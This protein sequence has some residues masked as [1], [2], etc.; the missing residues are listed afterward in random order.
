MHDFLTTFSHIISEKKLI[1]EEWFEEAWLSC[2]PSIYCSVDL[3][4]SGKKIC[5]VDTNLFPAGFNNLSEQAQK[6]A[7]NEFQKLFSSRFDGIKNI[8]IIAEQHTRNK[9]YVD[10]LHILKSCI[11]NAGF[12]VEI[13][14]PI[15]TSSEILLECSTKKILPA[16][17]LHKKA[18]KV[19]TGNDFVPDVIVLNNDL[20]S[21]VISILENIEQPIMPAL[22]LG[23]YARRKSH[24][25]SVYDKVVREFC[26]LI[27]LDPWFI[28]TFHYQCGA[29]NFKHQ[30]GL[31]CV[32]VGVE[33]LLDQLRR[34][35]KEYN[36]TDTP[37]VFIKSDMGTYGMAI[38]TAR[39][40]EDVLQANKKS[41][42]KMGMLKDRVEN[43]EV[44][45]QEG[46]PTR[47]M[48]NGAVAE[49]VI[50]V[51]NTTPVG[52]MYRVNA[53]RDDHANLNASGMEFVATFCEED[54]LRYYH[55]LPLTPHGIVARL[56]CLASAK[57]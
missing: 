3:R 4:D 53:S 2:G 48:V 33:K 7:S 37:Y 38:M 34:K 43:S 13:G 9:Y 40:G 22:E 47:N 32:A 26:A 41:R 14:Y 51:V 17:P 23:W 54:I 8:L 57:E 24:H 25:Y 6:K 18:G 55:E 42:N 11:E 36:I 31:E 12:N 56:A 19:M 49:P 16:Y 35:Y 15:D 5:P 46:V 21:G 20:T 28:S 10:N 27:D 30:K 50:Y 45:I 29:V 1:I 44:V 39:S 52:C